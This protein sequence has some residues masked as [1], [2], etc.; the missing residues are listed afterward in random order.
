MLVTGSSQV[1]GLAGSAQSSITRRKGLPLIW[2]TDVDDRYVVWQ[3]LGEFQKPRPVDLMDLPH[4]FRQFPSVAQGKLR[5]II[6]QFGPLP[7]SATPLP[8]TS[9]PVVN[10]QRKIDKNYR[11]CGSETAFYD[12]I[13][14]KSINDPERCQTP[15][16][17]RAPGRSLSKELAA[18]RVCTECCRHGA[19]G[20]LTGR[21][22]VSPR[23][24][25]RLVLPPPEFMIN[26]TLCIVQRWCNHS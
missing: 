24:R 5:A 23:R 3:V 16:I 7:Y 26:A 18:I 2:T 19:N 10:L 22:N 6:G 17:C 20:C 4:D 15:P 11:V 12:P 13:A 25:A 8:L 21:F 9:P 14:P 1:R